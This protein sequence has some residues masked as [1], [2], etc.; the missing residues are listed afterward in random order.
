MKQQL[1]ETMRLQKLA[2]LLKEFNDANLNTEAK[3]IDDYFPVESQEGLDNEFFEG[4]ITAMI[5]HFELNVEELDNMD[6]M[7]IAQKLKGALQLLKSRT[8]N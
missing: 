1:N 5:N 6:A 2:G 8:S 3:T 7:G 4:L